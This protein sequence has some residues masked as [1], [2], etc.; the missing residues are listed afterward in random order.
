MKINGSRFQTINTANFLIR[1]GV[2][3][4]AIDLRNRNTFETNDYNEFKNLIAS[5][6]FVYAFWDGT[7][8]TEDK[9]KNETKATIRCIPIDMD[10]SEGECI[11]SGNPT[12]K[13][14]IFAKS[15]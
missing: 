2:Y 14:V 10:N 9:I 12:R 5:G 11:Y 3:N 7:S 6:G 15:Y 8:L 1:H 4:R 13:K